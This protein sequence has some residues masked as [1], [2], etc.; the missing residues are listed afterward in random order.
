MLDRVIFVVGYGRSGST[1]LDIILGSHPEIFGAGEMSTICRHV[2]PNN[3]YC[4]CHEKVRSC[5][6][7]SPAISEWQQGGADIAAYKTLQKKI[8]PILAPDRILSRSSLQQYREQTL[9]LYRIV[10]QRTGRRVLLDSSKMPGRAM[11]LAG[12]GVD[13]LL[14]HLVRDPRAVAHSLTKPMK[15]D[16]E[17]GIQKILRSHPVARTALRWNFVNAAAEHALRRVPAGNRMQL[18]YEDLVADP[19][20]ALSR[21]G[22]MADMDLTSLGRAIASGEQVKAEHQVAGGRI[23][24]LD[25]VHLKSDMD[26][27]DKMSRSSQATVSRICSRQMRRYGYNLDGGVGSM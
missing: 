21:I 22:S 16:K 2:W 11:A 12:S 6:L 9:Q 27:K 24:M 1:L 5:P 17:G 19:E 14:I 7:W 20:G 15:I 10:A 25:S 23:R 26:W 4:A 13:L 8:E 18:R 3:E